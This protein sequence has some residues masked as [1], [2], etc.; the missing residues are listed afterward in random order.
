VNEF[1]KRSA[2]GT[3][4]GQNEVPLFLL[5]WPMACFFSAPRCTKIFAI[6]I[7]YHNSIQCP[8][9]L[10][11]KNMI[12]NYEHHSRGDGCWLSVV[13]GWLGAWAGAAGCSSSSGMPFTTQYQ[14]PYWLTKVFRPTQ[15]KNR[16][17]I[18]Q[19]FFPVGSGRCTHR[20]S[21]IGDIG[22]CWNIGESASAS[23]RCQCC[24]K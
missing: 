15:Q 5:Q 11:I 18:L 10:C 22:A 17:F 12:V 8:A 4:T 16:S 1:L 19:T 9:I 7:T 2:F 14:Q 23:R 13:T 21:K 6:E 24:K 20:T 3:G